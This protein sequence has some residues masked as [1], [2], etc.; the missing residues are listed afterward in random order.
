M[1]YIKQEERIILDNIVDMLV[2]Q[3][4]LMKGKLNY[5]LHKLFMEWIKENGR[6]YNNMGDFFKE[7]HMMEFELYARKVLPYETIKRRQNGD[8]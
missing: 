1:P 4:N 6:S 3:P 2:I 5:F 7:I 8:I